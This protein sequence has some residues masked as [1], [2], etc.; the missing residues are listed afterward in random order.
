MCLY[1]FPEDIYKKQHSKCFSSAGAQA[2][3][4]CWE[5]I[6][7]PDWS[8][9]LML[10]GGAAAF[11]VCLCVFGCHC[12]RNTNLGTLVLVETFVGPCRQ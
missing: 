5:F 6:E 7:S 12:L 9:T 4:E 11:C 8:S 1:G 10:Q 2:L 3:G